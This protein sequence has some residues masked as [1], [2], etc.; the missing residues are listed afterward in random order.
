MTRTHY[1]E[2]EHLK[3]G[4]KNLGAELTTI[5][6][7]SHHLEYLWQGD[8][9]F[10]GKQSPVLFPIVGTLRENKYFVGGKTY[11]LF[12]HGFAREE[13]FALESST[14][15]K[16]T[17]LLKSNEQTLSAYPFH[18]HFRIIYKLNGSTLSITYQIDNVA[19]D[20]MYFSVGAHPA[21]N[22]PL[23]MDKS[24]ESYYLKFEKKEFADK[25]PITPDGLLSKISEPFFDGDNIL[26]LTKSLFLKDALVFKDLAS[27]VIVL[28]SEKGH[29]IRME[30]P[31]F[32]YFGIWAAK[33][34][35][36]VCL[37]PWCGVADS[38]NHSQEFYNKEVINLLQGKEKFERTWNVSC[39]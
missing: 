2:N 19:K 12:R 30:F 27:E 11:T 37:E 36:F 39:Y 24:Y 18:F 26:P 4:V 29:G 31:G 38:E 14:P 21:F 5:F 22:V 28:E 25:W 32:P 15:S 13:S 1:L 33:H 35:D 20:P 3:V 10:W 9:A 34:A 8:P 23:E 16:L 17:F 7:K 6:N